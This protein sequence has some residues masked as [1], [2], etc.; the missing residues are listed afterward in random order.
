MATDTPTV[1]LWVKEC[2]KEAVRFSA[3]LSD[4]VE[5]VKTQ[6]SLEHCSLRKDRQHL[7]R[8]KTLEQCGV[9][10][11]DLITV[12]PNS[13]T[14]KGFASRAEYLAANR[15]KNGTTKQTTKH[16]Q[17]ITHTNLHQD[18]QQVVML[19][20][21]VLSQK[22][23]KTKE[24]LEEKIDNLQKS[25]ANDTVP[26][27]KSQREWAEKLNPLAVSSLNEILDKVSLPKKGN[28]FNKVMRLATEVEPRDL[29]K[30]LQAALPGSYQSESIPESESPHP[31]EDA[32][33]SAAAGKAPA[34]SEMETEV[35]DTAEPKAK[36][37]GKAK[38]KPKGKG[39][40]KAK[41]KGEDNTEAGK[42]R[43]RL[44]KDDADGAAPDLEKKQQLLRELERDAASGD[45]E[46]MKQLLEMLEAELPY[47]PPSKMINLRKQIREMEDELENAPLVPVVEKE[48]VNEATTFIT[49]KMVSD[50]VQ[51]L[52][53]QLEK[54][55]HDLQT[56]QTELASAQLD[57]ENYANLCESK[58]KDPR[59]GSELDPEAFQNLCQSDLEVKQTELRSK[60]FFLKAHVKQLGFDIESAKELLQQAKELA[61]KASEA[62]DAKELASEYDMTA[63]D[64]MKF[65]YDDQENETQNDSAP[66]EGEDMMEEV[67]EEDPW[68]DKRSQAEIDAEAKRIINRMLAVNVD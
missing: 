58:L 4:T 38:A 20:S 10:A 27:N 7:G 55:E 41:A 8:H 22:I 17:T 16:R 56:K 25:I 12:L 26:L 68:T 5:V 62:D 51:E 15:V 14:P 37:K 57:F 29:N 19:E 24:D 39:K 42:K 31:C 63:P 1:T 34:S 43:R 67:K 50:K 66:E 2:G 48:F 40:A 35:K 64:A 18:T 36:A 30:L 59:F 44:N 28:K 60:K 6:L 61:S 52:E 23:D 49:G 3:K 13:R 32:D 53:A 9:V 54:Y 47:H 33:S 21:Y 46:K 45:L 65:G 11:G